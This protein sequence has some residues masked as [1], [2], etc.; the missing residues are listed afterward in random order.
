MAAQWA[1]WAAKKV[2]HSIGLKG[3]AYAGERQAGVASPLRSVVVVVVV[4]VALYAAFWQN[5]AAAVV[6]AGGRN[7]G[8]FAAAISGPITSANR[9]G[10]AVAFNC[11][12]R[13]TITITL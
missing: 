1:V 4:V 8:G 12:L 11:D 5:P 9:S 7:R 3:A 10:F 2:V 6:A 13:F